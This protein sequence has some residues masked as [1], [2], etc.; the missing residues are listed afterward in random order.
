MDI[1]SVFLQNVNKKIEVQKTKCWFRFWKTRI[2]LWINFQYRTNFCWFLPYFWLLFLV[3]IFGSFL[4]PH[5]V[6]VVELY[7]M[8]EPF[9]ICLSN[10]SFNRLDLISSASSSNFRSVLLKFHLISRSWIVIR[11]MNWIVVVIA[12]QKWCICWIFV[13]VVHN[14]YEKDDWCVTMWMCA[15]HDLVVW[16]DGLTV[17][18]VQVLRNLHHR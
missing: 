11:N 14:W 5:I 4:W 8:I 16:F 3:L 13:V 7:S 18:G 6:I 15:A 9:H 17:L 12:K 1:W 2:S 10:K